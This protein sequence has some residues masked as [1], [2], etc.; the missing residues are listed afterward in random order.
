MVRKIDKILGE[1]KLG[2]KNVLIIRKCENCLVRR[3]L[4]NVYWFRNV[5]DKVFYS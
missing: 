4:G 2:L 3:V 1:W 5:E